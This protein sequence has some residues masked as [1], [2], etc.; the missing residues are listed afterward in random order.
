MAALLPRRPLQPVL[1]PRLLL[2]VLQCRCSSGGSRAE[3]LQAALTAA[4]ERGAP[5]LTIAG[6]T[7]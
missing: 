6:G 2:L 3:D 7:Y 1:L 5:S 4:I